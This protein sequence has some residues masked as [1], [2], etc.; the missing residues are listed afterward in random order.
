MR[1]F[2]G[3]LGWIAVW[4]YILALLNY[5]MKYINKL[6]SDK[7]Q[8]KDIY[9]IVMRY[10]IRY[11]KISGIVA[12]I[13]VIGYLYIMYN[14]V[15]LSISGFVSTVIMFIVV[16]LGIFSFF[17]IKSIRIRDLWIRVHR[18]LG[19]ILIFV[20]VFHVMFSRFLLIRK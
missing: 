12:S 3:L 2:A 20:I 15:G 14:F 19:V 7:R 4:G 16:A 13:F 1:Q 17:I 5:F 10:I 8:Y 6:P 18:M 11:H 9:R